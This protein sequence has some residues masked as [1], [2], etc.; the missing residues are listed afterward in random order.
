MQYTRGVP[1]HSWTTPHPLTSPVKTRMG[2][3]V[4][5]EVFGSC[6]AALPPVGR[7][8]RHPENPDVS[9]AEA[10]ESRSV[11]FANNA[12]HARIPNYGYRPREVLQQPERLRVHHPR[13]TARATCSCTS[14][15][16]SALACKPSWR[17]SASPMMWSPSAESRRRAICNRLDRVAH[18]PRFMNARPARR[19]LSSH[20]GG[21]RR[22]S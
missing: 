5:T 15:P 1:T 22:E 9:I 19:A 7:L 12:V 8:S 2:T 4:E 13:P 6:L 17:A 20:T 21:I 10:A 3:C 18:A 11:E 14:P 16:L